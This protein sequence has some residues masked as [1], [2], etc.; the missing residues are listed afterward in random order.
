MR[1]LAVSKFWRTIMVRRKTM[2]FAGIALLAL[3]PA[4]LLVGGCATSGGRDGVDGTN[5]ADGLDGT[6]GRTGATGR[7]GSTG[8]TGQTGDTGA[9]RTVIIDR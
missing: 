3:T 9:S 7:T 2:T 4:L 1:A 8:Q 6:T 5:G